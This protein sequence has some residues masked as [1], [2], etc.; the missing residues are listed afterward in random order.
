MISEEQAEM[1]LIARIA[2]GTGKEPLYGGVKDAEG[3]ASVLP[4]WNR[5]SSQ[6]DQVALQA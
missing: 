4:T 2:G 6:H 3:L 5:G 1:R